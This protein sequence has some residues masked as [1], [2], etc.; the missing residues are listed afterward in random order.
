MTTDI[1]L[2]TWNEA[3]EIKYDLAIL[4]WGAT[5]PHNFH[6]PYTTD[7]VLSR[8]VSLEAAKKAN[9]QGVNPMVLPA[10]PF[11]SQNPGQTDLIFCIHARQE[12]QKAILTDIVSSLHHQGLRKL[13]ILN[14]HGGNTFRTLVRDIQVDFPDFMIVV[15]DWY[16]LIDATQYFTEPGDHAGELETAMMM[17]FFP[18]RVKDKSAYGKGDSKKFK[19][20]N[21]NKGFWTPRHWTKVSSDTG[22]GNPVHATANNGKAFTEAVTNIIA[23]FIVDFAKADLTDMYTID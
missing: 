2:L 1:D 7:N 22:I 8:S 15:S 9:D 20:D 23:Q 19:I 6:L 16:K 17:H 12:T 13:V 18:E 11:G 21:L 10:I 3:K 5:E 4:P 14:G